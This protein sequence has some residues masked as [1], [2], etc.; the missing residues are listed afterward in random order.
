MEFLWPNR[1]TYLIMKLSRR[2]FLKFSF[3]LGLLPIYNKLLLA[4]TEF[5]SN[6]K[7]ILISIELRGGNDGLNTII[8]FR[9]EVYFSQRPNIAIN[10]YLKLNSKL[11][12]NPFM[13]KLFPLWEREN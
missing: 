12:L 5:K 10:E 1:F 6:S 4:N 3:C 11:A 2:K 8:P 9:D 7:S 13:R